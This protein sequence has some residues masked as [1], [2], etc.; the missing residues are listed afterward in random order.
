M[1]EPRHKASSGKLVRI[2]EDLRPPSNPERSASKFTVLQWNVLADGLAQFGDFEKADKAALSWE[3]RAPLLLAEVLEADADLVF[4]QECNR[5]SDFFE[6][7]L[8]VRG[9]AGCF[10]PKPCSPAEQYGFPCDGCAIFYRRERLEA[11]SKANGRPFESKDGSSSKQGS[12]QVLLRERR[13][14]C[15]LLAACCH[16]KAKESGENDVVRESQAA[17]LMERLAAAAGAA[18]G[19]ATPSCNGAGPAAP[20]VLLGGDFNTTPSAA[21]CRVVA[22][23]PLSLSSLWAEHAQPCSKADGACA[24]AGEPFTTWKF[25]PGEESRRISDYI[26][27]SR[28]A[29]L[30]PVRRW[31]ALTPG[32]IGLAGLP[33]SRYPSDHVAL[34]VVFELL[35]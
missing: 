11:V 35:A 9:Y 33:T 28:D 10:W 29:R 22:E 32:E 26:W 13:S 4:L 30:A 24:G 21:S 7:E 5:Y 8:R 27:F 16:L 1:G 23:H 19:L 31:R 2:F 25:R 14:G 34:C 3:A 15:L 6:P 18:C 17:Q 12:L 20:L